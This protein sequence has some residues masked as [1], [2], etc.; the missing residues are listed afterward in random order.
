MRFIYLIVPSPCVHVFLGHIAL[1]VSVVG[2]QGG[3][4]VGPGAPQVVCLLRP[5]EDRL[6]VRDI[7][8]GDILHRDA[9]S[10]LLLYHLPALAHL[11]FHW[12]LL[13]GLYHDMSTQ[14]N[15]VVTSFNLLLLPSHL[16]SILLC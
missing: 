13:I 2:V 16:L 4:G 5:V 12:L 14:V 7:E 6:G 11:F 15:H 9:P 3:R 1:V 8:L 10:R